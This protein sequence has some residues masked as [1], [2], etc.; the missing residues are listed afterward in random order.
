MKFS[1]SDAH[2]AESRQYRLAQTA[3]QTTYSLHLTVLEESNPLCRPHA[4]PPRHPDLPLSAAAR[5]KPGGLVSVGR[6]GARAGAPHGQ[7][8]LLSVGYSACHWCHVMAHESFED[9]EIAA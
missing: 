1:T 9:P 7:P 6:R 2:L 4:Q 8:I 5:G 3:V